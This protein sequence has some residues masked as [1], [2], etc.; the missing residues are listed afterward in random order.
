M[1]VWRVLQAAVE[2][3]ALAAILYTFLLIAFILI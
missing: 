1:I 2:L 3:I